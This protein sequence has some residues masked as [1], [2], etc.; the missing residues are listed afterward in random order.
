MVGYVSGVVKGARTRTIR[1]LVDAAPISG[2][3]FLMAF[4]FVVL[5]TN[6]AI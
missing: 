5:V 3:N 6:F 1:R 2:M 4:Y